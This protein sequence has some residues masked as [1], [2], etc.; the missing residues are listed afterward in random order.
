[1]RW[2]EEH[3]IV[4]R[5]VLDVDPM[6]L[7]FEEDDNFDEYDPEVR[8]IVERLPEAKTVDDLTAMIW[9]VFKKFFSEEL[10]G[11]PDRYRRIAQRIL[12]TRPSSATEP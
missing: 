8:E 11:S 1:M 9:E 7:Y 5:V 6:D 3:E 4:R 2:S 10:V 12:E